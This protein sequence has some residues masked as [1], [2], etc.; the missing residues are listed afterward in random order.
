M[1]SASA[2]ASEGDGEGGIGERSVSTPLAG[3]RRGA[4]HGSTRK[5]KDHLYLNDPRG[6]VLATESV[7]PRANSFMRAIRGRERA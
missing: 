7:E 3:G 4:V 5:G 2:S 6:Q 1:G